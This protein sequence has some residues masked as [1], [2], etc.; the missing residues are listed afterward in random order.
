MHYGDKG[1][2]YILK[3]GRLSEN[4]SLSIEK[5]IARMPFRTRSLFVFSPIPFPGRLLERHWRQ[6]CG[7]WTEDNAIG[8]L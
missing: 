8:W 2:R 6:V 1:A 7:L 4:C 3:G 5:Q